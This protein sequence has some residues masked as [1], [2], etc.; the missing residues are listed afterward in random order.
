MQAVEAQ[1]NPWFIFFSGLGFGH[2]RRIAY[3]KVI[4]LWLR[5][6]LPQRSNI[7]GSGILVRFLTY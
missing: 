7:M 6:A 5:A 1:S 4:D 3:P 2:V